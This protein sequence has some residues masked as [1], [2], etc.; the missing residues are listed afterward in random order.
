MANN[1]NKIKVVVLDIDQ[2]LT[3]DTAS[4]LQFTNLLG[5]DSE[6]H[7]NI[8]NKFK[9]GKISYTK[10][11]TQLISLWRCVSKLDRETIREIFK[12]IELRE[13]AMEAVEYL[14]Q[15]Y[16]LCLISGAID[17]FVDVIS[18]KLGIEDKYASTKFI[19]DD[20]GIL[21]DFKYKLSRGEEK[22]GYLHDFCDKYKVDPKNCAAIGDGESDVPIFNEV[23][24]PVL[25]IAEE[26]NE[27][28]KRSIKVQIRN[29]DEIYKYL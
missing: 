16:K 15:K 18:E 8:Y 23:G 27:R 19:F 9:E 25:F 28:L 13:G 4:W 22:V 6:I 20:R 11:K 5:T 17:I 7:T 1:K 3:I 12:K 29:W 10:A 21:K 26:T 14:K 24:L 2:T